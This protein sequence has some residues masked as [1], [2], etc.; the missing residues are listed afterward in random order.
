MVQVERLPAIPSVRGTPRPAGAAPRPRALQIVT[1]LNVGGPA[2]QVLPLMEQ[3]APRGF[4][5]RLVWGA[6]GPGEGSLD[7]PS[8]MPATYLPHLQRRLS[9]G[10]DLRAFRAIEGLVRR[11]RPQIVHTNLAKAGALG[12]LA[13]IHR[14]V[15]VVVHTFH[16][17]VLQEYFDPLVNRAFVEVERRLAA[18]THALLA[19]APEVRNELLALGIGRPSQWHVVPV[20]V[21]LEHLVLERPDRAAAR[22]ALGLPLNGPVVG[23]VGRLVPIKDHEV[24]LQ[25]GARLLR[26]R[27][28]VTFAVAGDGE[29]RERLRARAQELMGDRCVF[30]GWVHDLPTLYAA[31]DVV[32]LTSK[33]EGT[34]VSLIE[35]AAAG[36]PVVATRVGGVR[37][38]VRDGETGLLVAPDDPVAVAASLHTLLDDPEGA[39]RMGREGTDWVTGR[40]SASLLADRL[41]DLY[42]DLLARARA[43]AARA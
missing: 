39:R 26:E 36:K 3:L 11:W 20:G 16:G 23:C 9:L 18:R 21:E 22:A 17:H 37:E 35:A 28:D 40:F 8:R 25:A 2:R 1:R 32:A 43:R 15:P 12:R 38:V 30:L 7:P 42:T 19:V 24:L 31:V 33:L 41:A 34:P 4:D 29:L 14:R 13:A 6:V 5:V 10:D 27:P